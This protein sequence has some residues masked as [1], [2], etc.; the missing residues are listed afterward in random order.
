MNVEGEVIFE[1]AAV[2]I[3]E[4]GARLELERDERG[5][6]WARV[7]IQQA[8]GTPQERWTPLSGVERRLILDREPTGGGIH[9]I[10]PDR[11]RT[12][13]IVDARLPKRDDDPPATHIA[14]A[15]EEGF[16]LPL[17]FCGK[18]IVRRHGLNR[19]DTVSMIE[20]ERCRIF[21]ESRSK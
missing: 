8:A 18:K 3:D 17:T 15:E 16:K 13:E 2:Y 21:M 7:E 4:V 14:F 20:C 5:R 10:F 6:V 12:L 11:W 1:V 19:T 9:R